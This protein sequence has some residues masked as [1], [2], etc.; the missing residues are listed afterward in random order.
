MCRLAYRKGFTLIE[1]LLVAG[2]IC[3]IAGIVIVALAPRKNLISAYDAK[4]KYHIKEIQS[5]MTTYLIDK[6]E[7]AGGGEVRE[8]EINAKPICKPSV[9]AETCISMG[10]VDLGTLPPE[11]ITDLP[12]DPAE[13]ELSSCTGY[14]VYE[15]AGR[16]RVTSSH[17][18]ELPGEGS[19]TCCVSGGDPYVICTCE[20]LQGITTMAS[21]YALT[22]DVLCEDFGAFEPI[23]STFT[24][25]FD[26]GGNTIRNLTINK[27][28]EPAAMFLYIGVG[29]TVRDLNLENVNIAGGSQV[30]PL[31]SLSQGAIENVHVTGTVQGDE[32]AGGLIAEHLVADAISRSSANVDVTS[33]NAMAGGLVA[34]MAAGTIVDSYA[35]GDVTAN[36]A[37]LGW[38]GGLV[39]RLHAGTI[40]NSY[41]TG[42]V[43]GVM[44]AGGLV[45]NC[46][47]CDMVK[48]SYSTG[49]V[50]GSSKVGGFAGDS[51]GYSPVNSYWLDRPGDDATQCI[52]W[53]GGSCTALGAESDVFDETHNVYDTS[54]PLWDFTSIWQS[55]NPTGYPSLQ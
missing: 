45:G 12:L 55:N 29:S 27:P 25:T 8:G 19:S 7:A 1:L 2:M 43:Y 18:G 35:T 22:S 23:A 13:P 24:G 40:E 5:S 48:N 17:F 54:A 47:L 32:R 38:A 9:P 34:E 3:M 46:I 10:G 41:A 30:A 31:A 42:N 15:Q 16:P 20:D 50:R 33:N 28:G 39:G 21:D 44:G 11:F 4:R 36:S 49:E 26:G 37:T 14:M 52:G 53:G 6:W 51:N